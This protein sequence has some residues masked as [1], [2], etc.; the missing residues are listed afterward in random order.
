MKVLLINGSPNK[1]GC[2]YTALHEVE[3]TLQQNGIETEMLYLGKAPV[4]GCI[5]CMNCMTT[6][7]CFQKDIVRDIQMRWSL[8]NL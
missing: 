7:F 6:G 8:C 1:K 4:A 5:A 3:T 2:T